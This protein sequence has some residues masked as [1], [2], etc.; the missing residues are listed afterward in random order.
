MAQ[1]ST[2]DVDVIASSAQAR[3]M[4]EDESGGDEKSE[5]RKRLEKLWEQN[6]SGE[7]RVKEGD[8]FKITNDSE[9]IEEAQRRGEFSDPDHRPD[10]EEERRDGD[11]ESDDRAD[12]N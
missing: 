12:S 8:D 5:D 11:G 2:V 3:G 6:S 1:D 4:S 10:D 7:I 9:T